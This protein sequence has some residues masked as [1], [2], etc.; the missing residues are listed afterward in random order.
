M[1]TLL[2]GGRIIDPFNDRDEIGDLWIEDGR[3]IARAA[4]APA[5]RRRMMSPAR[6]SWPARSTFIRISPAAM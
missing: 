5:G 4:G 6:S 1:L 3:I 2:K